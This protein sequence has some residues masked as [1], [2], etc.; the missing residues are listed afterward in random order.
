ML[1]YVFSGFTISPLELLSVMVYPRLGA[2]IENKVFT[3]KVCSATRETLMVVSALR[4]Q[5]VM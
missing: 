2:L 4:I 1:T 3:S 5:L